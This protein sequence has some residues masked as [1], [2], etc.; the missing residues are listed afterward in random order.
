MKNRLIT[1]IRLFPSFTKYILSHSFDKFIYQ[2]WS[3]NSSLCPLLIW[4]STL[5]FRAVSSSQERVKGN[6]FN[7]F[8]QALL[9]SYI[10]DWFRSDF[11]ERV[12]RHRRCVEVGGEYFEKN[13]VD[14]VIH[15][16]SC[17]GGTYGHVCYHIA[18][19]CVYQI[20]ILLNVKKYHWTSNGGFLMAK[21][22]LYP[23]IR[24]Y[25]Y[26]ILY[27]SKYARS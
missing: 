2:C 17:A 3:G 21:F 1:L 24:V 9:H 23:R 8:A 12:V 13:T 19:C 14:V 4:L 20:I 16:V 10:S 7:D 6:R 15:N 26:N 5:R 18:I 22:W 27:K 11:Q 25:I